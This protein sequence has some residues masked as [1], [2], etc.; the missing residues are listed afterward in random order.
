M[1]L[2]YVGLNKL[3]FFIRAQKNKLPSFLHSNVVYRINCSNW[4]VS[5]VGQTKHLLKN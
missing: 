1:H 5:Y 2:A 3:N 4:D